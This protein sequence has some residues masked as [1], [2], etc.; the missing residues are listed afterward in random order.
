MKTDTLKVK[1]KRIRR[2]L[3]ER[4]HLFMKKYAENCRYSFEGMLKI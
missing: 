1:T 4:I 2:S 3:L